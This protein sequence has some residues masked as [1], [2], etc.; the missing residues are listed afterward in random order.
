MYPSWRPQGKCCSSM[1]FT[2]KELKE[3]KNVIPFSYG[4]FGIIEIPGFLF[5]TAF[6]Q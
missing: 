6:K 1:K 2:L 5:Y 4:N 3:N